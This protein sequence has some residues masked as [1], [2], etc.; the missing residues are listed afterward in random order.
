MNSDFLKTKHDAGLIYADYLKTG[1][2]N[3]QENWNQ[4]YRQLELNDD[5]K[6]LLGGFVRKMNVIVVS[7]IWCGD[8]AQI[9]PTL[10][11]IAEGNPLI[12]LRFVD[13]DEHLDLAE[14]LTVNAGQRVPAVVFCAEDYEQV[15][16]Y[17]DK[18]ISRYRRIAAQSLGGA[19]CALPGAP[20]LAEQQ[21]EE[22]GDWLNEFERVHHVLRLSGR[23]RKIHND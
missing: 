16:W 15:G 4:N 11:K 17:G 21:Q 9:G 23:L 6:S 20:I 22:L 12:D 1:K 19:A 7:G 14:H 5:Q 2:E 8:C 18:T 3:Q 13:R 10:A